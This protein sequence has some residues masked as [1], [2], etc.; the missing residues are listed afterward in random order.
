MYHFNVIILD[1]RPRFLE[2]IRTKFSSEYKKRQY[3]FEGS[4]ANVHL[5]NLRYSNWNRDDVVEIFT[6]VIDGE[7]LNADKSWGITA[8]SEG[9]R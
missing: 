4:K 5:N 9:R 2:F 6:E 8:A 7:R 1:L 3:R